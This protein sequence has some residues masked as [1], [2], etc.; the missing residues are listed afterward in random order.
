MFDVVKRKTWQN[1][2]LGSSWDTRNELLVTDVSHLMNNWKSLGYNSD[3][4]TARTH[5]EYNPDGNKRVSSF[6]ATCQEHDLKCL[7]G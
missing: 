1:S 7:T 3:E 5:G 2:L 6:T 4:S